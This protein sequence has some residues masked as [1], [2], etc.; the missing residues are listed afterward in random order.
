MYGIGE[1]NGALATVLLCIVVSCTYFHSICLR[2]LNK[3]NCIMLSKITA[4]LYV[5]IVHDTW[6]TL[7][8]GRNGNKTKPMQT[9]CSIA[10]KN[11]EEKAT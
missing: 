5:N 2:N 3:L 9:K 4:S 11:F 10:S 8:R 1:T 7:K 6:S